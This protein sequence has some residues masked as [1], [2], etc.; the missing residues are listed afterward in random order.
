M[1]L[2]CLTWT[3]GDL[4]SL[5][6]SSN[7]CGDLRRCLAILAV[8]FTDLRCFAILAMTCIDL[9]FLASV[10]F[11]RTQTIEHKSVH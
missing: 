5:A 3:S 9:R 4:H 10:G 6:L 1:D 2:R 8:T 11:E 7:T